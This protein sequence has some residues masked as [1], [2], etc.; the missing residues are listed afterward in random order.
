MHSALPR[1][2]RQ[3][4]FVVSLPAD[5]QH[6]VSRLY[7]GSGVDAK[8]AA[9]RVAIQIGRCISQLLLIQ[10]SGPQKCERTDNGAP[11]CA[12]IFVNSF[13]ED[14][15]TRPDCRLTTSGRNGAPH[16]W[17]DL[18]GPRIGVQGRRR[19]GGAVPR[20]TIV[21]SGCSRMRSN[22]RWHS[23]IVGMRGSC[24]RL[25]TPRTSETRP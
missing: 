3:H 19:A 15:R 4:Y 12:R 10:G 2:R 1:P 6:A 23:S 11:S 21:R 13:S 20:L 24:C 5:E 9:K 18:Q 8:S 14:R 22:N 16:R 7:S 17:A 25:L